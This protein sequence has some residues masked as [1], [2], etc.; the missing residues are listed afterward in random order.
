MITLAGKHLRASIKTMNINF[1]SEDYRLLIRITEENFSETPV[2]Y[3]K[4]S[5]E[6]EYK[7]LG[8]QSSYSIEEVTMSLREKAES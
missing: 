2:S 8:F 7:N 3:P 6:T 4:D 1:T 5:I